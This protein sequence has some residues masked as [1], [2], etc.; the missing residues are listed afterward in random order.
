[1]TQQNV[2]NRGL[3][4][5]YLGYNPFTMTAKEALENAKAT[6]PYSLPFYF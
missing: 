6:N 1:L 2:S 4:V 5:E 3:L